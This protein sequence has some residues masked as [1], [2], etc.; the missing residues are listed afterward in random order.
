MWRHGFAQ[1][2][3]HPGIPTESGLTANVPW[4]TEGDPTTGWPYTR[5]HLGHARPALRPVRV[6]CRLFPLVTALP[7]T[8]S[9]THRGAWFAGFC[10]TMLVSDCSGPYITGVEFGS[11]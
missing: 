3:L 1:L 4:A 9:A 6:M 5:Q 2:R 7:S 10:G 11:S 8:H